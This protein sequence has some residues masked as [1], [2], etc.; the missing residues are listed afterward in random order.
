MPAPT[1]HGRFRCPAAP[2]PAQRWGLDAPDQLLQQ[3]DTSHALRQPPASQH[4]S[5]IVFDLDVMVGLSPIIANKQH[6]A[7]SL[8]DEHASNR[9]EGRPNG[10]LLCPVK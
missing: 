9:G 4:S 3:R 6:P 7:P 8:F 5:L 1:A 2:D 10:T